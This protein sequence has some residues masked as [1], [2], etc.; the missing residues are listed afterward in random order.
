MYD[1]IRNNN[2]VLPT[3]SLKPVYICTAFEQHDRLYAYVT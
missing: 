1:A 2:C 3:C